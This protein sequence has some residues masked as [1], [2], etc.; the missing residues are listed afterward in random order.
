MSVAQETSG[1]A[2]YRQDCRAH[3]ADGVRA[4]LLGF[5]LLHVALG[6]LVAIEPGVLLDSLDG[7][8]ERYVVALATFE[9][10]LGL[11]LLAAVRLR[12]WRVPM[13]AFATLHWVLVL[14][15]ALGGAPPLPGV[16]G[17]AV[18]AG[19]LVWLLVHAIRAERWASS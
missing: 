5:G 9:L 19:L 4:G 18:G 3:P 16:A 7:P 6:L 15:V 2:G 17:L 1:P 10:S 14:L 12:S 13:L 11:A 8:G